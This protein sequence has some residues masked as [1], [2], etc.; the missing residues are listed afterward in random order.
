MKNFI[1]LAKQV[2][3]GEKCYYTYFHIDHFSTFVFYFIFI[4]TQLCFV[5]QYFKLK[6]YFYFLLNYNIFTL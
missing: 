6:M 4:F 5:L 3:Y 1:A 2:L